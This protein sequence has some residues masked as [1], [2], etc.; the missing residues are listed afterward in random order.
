VQKK[1]AQHEK[2]EMYKRPFPN[3]VPGKDEQKTAK[4]EK[5]GKTHTREV[6]PA[7]QLAPCAFDVQNERL[8]A[9]FTV[10]D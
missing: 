1:E 6:I 3:T 5:K 7:R 9:Q 8:T 2:G 10:E 4:K